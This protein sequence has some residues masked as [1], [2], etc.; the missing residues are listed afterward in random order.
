MLIIGHYSISY[1]LRLV[2]IHKFELVKLKLQLYSGL[3]K[4]NDSKRHPHHVTVPP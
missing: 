3:P 1:V 2:G 4:Q